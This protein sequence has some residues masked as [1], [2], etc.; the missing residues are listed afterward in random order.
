MSVGGKTE[1]LP[2]AE[3]KKVQKRVASFG[4]QDK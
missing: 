3:K 4:Q 2:K 1:R